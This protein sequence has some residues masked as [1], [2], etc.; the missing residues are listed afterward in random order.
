MLHRYVWASTWSS[1]KCA[2]EGITLKP[3]PCEVMLHRNT[4]KINTRP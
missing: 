2:C 3:I 1:I 4:K